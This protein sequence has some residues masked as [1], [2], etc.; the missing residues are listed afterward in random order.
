M[1]KNLLTFVGSVTLLLMHPL[2]Q[3]ASDLPPTA[4]V[5]MGAPEEVCSDFTSPEW[6]KEQ[7]IDGVKIQASQL[8]N[9]DNPAEIA[10]FVKGTNN[11]SMATLM[12]TQLAADAI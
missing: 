6:R 1:R 10:A 3:A 7:V 5:K 9:P 2:S 12:E 8:C 4:N 11:V